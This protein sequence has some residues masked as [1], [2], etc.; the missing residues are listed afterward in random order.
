[1]KG[2]LNGIRNPGRRVSVAGTAA[3]EGQKEITTTG[4]GGDRTVGQGKRP[5][6]DQKGRCLVPLYQGSRLRSPRSCQRV[7][8][9]K[10]WQK[11]DVGSKERILVD[12]PEEHA[13]KPDWEGLIFF[14]ELADSSKKKRSSEGSSFSTGL[15]EGGSSI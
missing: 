1:M 2:A 7:D 12:L 11:K 13:W 6:R 4:E 14:S 15:Y 8:G 10:E 9:R 5:R 3:P